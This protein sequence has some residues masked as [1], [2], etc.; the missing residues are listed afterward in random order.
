MGQDY[1]RVWYIAAI[2]GVGPDIATK[3][4]YYREVTTKSQNWS[5]V[6]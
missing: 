6:V 3:A 2:K 1:I 4:V 5:G